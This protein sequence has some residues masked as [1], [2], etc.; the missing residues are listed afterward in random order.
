MLTGFFLFYM[1]RAISTLRQKQSSPTLEGI[2][3]TWCILSVLKYTW[4]GGHHRTGWYRQFGILFVRKEKVQYLSNY[5]QTW[6]YIRNVWV[7]VFKYWMA[8]RVYMH[9][10]VRLSATLWTVAW[11]APLFMGFSGK[12]TGSGLP[13]PSSEDLLDPGIGPASPVSPALQQDSLHT[14]P[15]GKSLKNWILRLIPWMW[16]RTV[17]PEPV[18]RT[19][20]LSVHWADVDGESW[21]KGVT[22]LDGGLRWLR[23]WGWVERG[24]WG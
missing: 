5:F 13:H 20:K 15:S 4:L 1:S 22:I 19:V 7:I 3:L 6:L 10:H 9:S 23:A 16:I 2:H 11:Q 24:R 18:F 8:W 12:N 21:R 14:E 17:A